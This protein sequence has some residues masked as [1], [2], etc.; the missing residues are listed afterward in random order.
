MIPATCSPLLR[1]PAMPEVHSRPLGQSRRRPPV[2]ERLERAGE[3]PP[4]PR[5]PHRRCG[6]GLH[7]RRGHGA[8]ARQAQAFVLVRHSLR[9]RCGLPERRPPPHPRLPP[10]SSL[11]G[12]CEG[13]ARRDG[14]RPR[15]P[16]LPLDEAVHASHRLAGGRGRGGR[17]GTRRRAGAG[18]RVRAV[19]AEAEE[20]VP[21]AARAHPAAGSRDRVLPALPQVAA[22]D[23]H[24]NRCILR[25]HVR[26]CDVRLLSLSLSPVWSVSQALRVCFKGRALRTRSV[27]VE[28]EGGRTARSPII[29]S[30]TACCF[31]GERKGA[32]TFR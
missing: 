24:G 31:E 1:F 32:G 22:A 12:G 7:G 8:G 20:P 9:V 10:A 23:C 4:P 30:L 18:S 17:G 15:D 2:P 21:E 26:R 6:L 11:S 27:A 29:R 5:R 19:G 3:V 14:P 25:L 13:G 16:V 28:K